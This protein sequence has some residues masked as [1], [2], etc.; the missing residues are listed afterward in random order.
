MITISTQTKKA[1]SL[2]N[3][4]R[5]SFDQMRHTVGDTQYSTFSEALLQRNVPQLFGMKS[6]YVVDTPI[7]NYLREN[8]DK[9]SS[10]VAVTSRLFF[11]TAEINK[12]IDEYINAHPPVADNAQP[13]LEELLAKVRNKP[14]LA[15]LLLEV[16]S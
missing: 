5:I 1:G 13:E 9:F 4:V 2:A 7:Y 15:K 10:Y 8:R 3:A 6:N 16:I 11:P 12:L 14:E